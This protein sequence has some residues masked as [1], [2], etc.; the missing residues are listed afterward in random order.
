M[1]A[2][3]GITRYID[4]VDLK[5]ARPQYRLVYRRGPQVTAL[6]AFRG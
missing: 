2:F 3:A 5:I 6:F 4:L 1:P